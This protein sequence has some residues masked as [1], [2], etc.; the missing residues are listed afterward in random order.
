MRLTVRRRMGKSYVKVGHPRS[1]PGS[2]LMI[3][4]A[5]AATAVAVGKFCLFIFR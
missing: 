1:P 4:R 2:A 3:T 5:A